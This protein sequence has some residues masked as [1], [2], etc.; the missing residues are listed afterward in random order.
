MST[1]GS[2]K[3][4][5]NGTWSF[6]TNVVPGPVGAR[7][8][9]RKRG[10]ATKK[11]AQEALD[12][13]RTG[14]RKG[15]YVPASHQSLSA[16]LDGWLEGLPTS[17]LRP[18]TIDGYRRNLLYVRPTLGGRRLDQLTAGDL[19]RLYSELLAS[20]LRLREGGLS[21]R[22]VR[23]VHVVISKALGDAV[24]RGELARNVAEAASPPSAKSAR[25][26]EMAWWTPPQLRAFL[27][28]IAGEPLAALIRVAGMTGM[29]R[30]E[31]CGLR[32]ADVDLER[33]RVHV[34]Q[35]L[36]TLNGKLIFSARTKTDRGRRTI[37][38]DPATAA[39]VRAQRARQAEHRLILGGTY[40]DHDLVFAH[41]DGT[42][43]DPESVAKVFDRRVARSGLPRIRFHDL[44]HSHVAHLI[45]AG[46]QPLLI[47][48]RLG[49]AS[50]SFT[51]DRYGHLFEDAGSTAAA[52]V[53]AMVDG[54]V[55]ATVTNK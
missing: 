43:L 31:V 55:T 50:A 53:A 54:P 10:F 17:G 14:V 6:V 44:R 12:E 22:S 1:A 37:D 19:D 13:L 32:W 38:L 11:E 3:Q 34:R 46:E 2:L 41:V 5:P 7:R 9:A 8:Q 20:G 30:G 21:P 23:Y 4:Q 25:P 40:E 18:S 51:M 48:R 36:T 16:Y 26:P 29:R 28:F 39:V 35:Q 33:G 42:P 27:D 47:A 24:R 15:T 49:H 52:A 45:A